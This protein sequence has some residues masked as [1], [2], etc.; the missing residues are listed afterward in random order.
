[1]RLSPVV[2]APWRGPEPRTSAPRI[3]SV[4]GSDVGVVIYETGLVRSSVE[5]A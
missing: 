3:M 4:A 5:L 1:L 2:D